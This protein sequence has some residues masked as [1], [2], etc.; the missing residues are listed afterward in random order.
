M[1]VA[2]LFLR[3]PPAGGISTV[4]PI[5]SWQQGI[6]MAANQGSTTMRNSPDVSLV[7]DNINVVWG[8]TL[9]GSSTDWTVTGTSLATPLWA[10]FMALV[11][12]Q[13]AAN[14]QPPIGF[15]NPALY[16]IGK[17]SN[18]Q[19]CFTTSPPAATPTAPVQPNTTRPPVMT[20]AP[21][22]AR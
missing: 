5:P 18:Y 15:A 3:K 2:T 20:S 22:G 4:Y 11:N 21:A 13:A 17:S 9:I 12:Q 14:G 16:A 10:G 19:S 7:A 1:N 6:S 8:N